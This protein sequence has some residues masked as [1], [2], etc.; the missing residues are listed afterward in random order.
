[1]ATPYESSFHKITTV[2]ELVPGKPATFRA[3]GA[4]IVLERTGDHVSA[5]D[6]ESKET[7]QLPVRVENGEVWVCIDACRS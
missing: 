2:A 5:I 6:G 4:T 3:A 7:E 1:M